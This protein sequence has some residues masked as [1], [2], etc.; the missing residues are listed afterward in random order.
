MKTSIT[1]TKN[2]QER[3]NRRLEE[4]AEERQCI[5]EDTV[6]ESNQAEQERQNY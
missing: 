3:I 5:L 4:A 6:M 1:E 2:Q